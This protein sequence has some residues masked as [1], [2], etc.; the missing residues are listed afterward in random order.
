MQEIIS[1][2]KMQNRTHIFNWD[3]FREVPMIGIFRNIP[4]ADVAQ[5]LPLCATAGIR[6]LEITMNTERAG[7]IISYAVE[8]FG[9][10][11]NIGAGTVCCMED[12]KMALDHGASF[13]V[14]PNLDPEVILECVKRGIQ[15]F[16]GAFTPTEIYKAWKLGASMV[17]V[18]PADNLGTKFISNVKAPFGT[19]KLLPT[20][21]IGMSN[22]LDYFKAGADGVGISNGLF[23]KTMIANK[24]W[25]S[26]EAHLVAFVSLLRK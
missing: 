26:L 21:G 11:L 2:A 7:E 14:T 20:G 19:I 17:K 5:I 23:D 4:L 16:P 10:Q 12:L 15:V 8:E 6:T 22:A 9:D 24:D 3:Y 13:I 25:K 18:F 1:Q